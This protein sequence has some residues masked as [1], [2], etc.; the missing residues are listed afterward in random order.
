[1]QRTECLR[2]A[3]APVGRIGRGARRL[4][5]QLDEAAELVA[6][7][8]ER[9]RHASTTSREVVRPAAIAS[10][11]S[12]SVALD[13]SHALASSAASEQRGAEIRRIEIEID[14]A[15]TASMAA[16]SC[17]SSIGSSSVRASLSAM[18]A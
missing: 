2:P 14:R 12:V 10:A 5:I 15:S 13:Q 16:R 4:G 11:V 8:R 3:V 6:E 18:P 9:S 17:S 1:M 7:P